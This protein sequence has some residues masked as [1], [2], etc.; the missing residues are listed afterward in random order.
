MGHVFISYS[1][2]DTEVVEKIIAELE[3]AGIEVWV[4]REAI[5]A[6]KQW[7]KHILCIRR[8]NYRWGIS[9][10]TSIQRQSPG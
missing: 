1:R 3:A 8:I 9:S 2:R 7:R 6:G 10:Y 4:D 5:K